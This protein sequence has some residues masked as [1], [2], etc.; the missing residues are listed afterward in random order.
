MMIYLA[1]SV[2][3]LAERRFNEELAAELERHCPALQVF[4]S[5]AVRQ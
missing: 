4:F 3:T 2:F 1:G 5:A